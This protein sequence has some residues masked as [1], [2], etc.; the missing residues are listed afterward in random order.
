V[1][2]SAPDISADADPYT[3]MAVGLL[4]FPK[5][6]GSPTY[7]ETD[8]G[9][10]SLAAP[11]VAGLVTAAQQGQAVPFGFLNPVLYKLHATDAYYGTLPLTSHSPA[12]D[13]R[14]LSN[15]G[16]ASGDSGLKTA[17]LPPLAVRMWVAPGSGTL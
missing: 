4:T 3:G 7:G 6:G 9:G 11:V 5:G 8:V 2:R 13:S 15:N 16:T 10:T 17:R 14:G 12:L 1:V